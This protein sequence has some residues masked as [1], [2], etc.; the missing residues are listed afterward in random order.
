MDNFLINGYLK[1]YKKEIFVLCIITIIT[2]LFSLISPLFV[3]VIVDE[4]ILNK[5]GHLLK[6]ILINLTI[7][8][9]IS[10][11]A[12]YIKNYLSEYIKIKIFQKK[13]ME[14][15]PIIILSNEYFN[16]GDL[17]S[18]LMDNLRAITLLVCIFLPN[19]VL[20]IITLIVPL[21]IMCYI[22]FR[23][24]VVTIF[25]A[26]AFVLI[27]YILGD[28]IEKVEEKLLK[29]NSQ[30]FSFLKESISIKEFIKSYGIID[31]FLKK[32]FIKLNSYKRESLVY[33][34]YSSISMSLE[35]ILTGIPMLILF[36][37]GFFLI[38][39][40]KLTLGS[41][42]AFM[43]YVSLFFNPMIELGSNWIAYKSTLPAIVRIEEIYN[44]KNQINGVNGELYL[45]EGIIEFVNVNFSYSNK[46]KILNK[47]NQIFYPGINYID[48]KNGSGKSTILKLIC[49]LHHP[50]DGLI[51]I[52][53]QN[54]KNVSMKSISKNIGIVFSKS[55]LFEDTIYNNIILD[56]KSIKREDV[57]NICKKINIH[58]FI[59]SLPNQ[60]NTVINED[61]DNLSSG[62]K[63]KISL[64]RV[65][66]RNPKILL[67]DE[68]TRSID[69]ESKKEI[70][71]CILSLKNK[72][73]IILIDHDFDETLCDYIIK[74]D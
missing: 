20:N 68:V 3:Q 27:F 66:L 25:P 41:F 28:K 35:Y 62:E 22:N 14:L 44:L 12:V 32:F 63:Q 21:I 4:V 13:L 7:F 24:C 69:K 64:V 59:M 45:T 74:M 42:M 6:L 33:A 15:I 53:N 11:I 9:F 18:R 26:L 1:E 5:N 36:I 65:L 8:Y 51:K 34:K 2:S 30:I 31:F 19:M 73:T 16:S 40:E 61:G 49:K 70:N 39:N 48:G 52:D 58:D 56:N 71:Q 54:I 57:V 37:Y 43:T 67:L 50:Q 46:Q 17:I 10:A 38:I 72:K 29:S 23:L 60:Y 47:F 55:Y